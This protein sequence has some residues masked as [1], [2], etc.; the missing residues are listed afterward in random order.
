M[1]T[2]DD[3]R[4]QILNVAGP[5][6]AEK[7][8]ERATVREICRAAGANLAA[9]NYYFGDK[10]QLYIKTVRLAHRMRAQQVPMPQWPVEATPAE[11]LRGFIKTL[12]TRM[13][14]RER[15]PWQT[16]LMMREVLRPTA[17]CKELVQEYFRPQFEQLWKS[18]G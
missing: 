8:F 18:L 12:I 5:V 3:T 2:G 17:A 4:D 9:V 14:G 15:A 13:V 7:G 11:K 6:F 10:E 16:R 1:S